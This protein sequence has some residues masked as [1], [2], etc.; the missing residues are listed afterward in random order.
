MKK[1]IPEKYDISDN[2]I[3]DRKISG[4][5]S[6]ISASLDSNVELV[7]G[8]PGFPITDIMNCFLHRSNIDSKWITNEKSALETA[9]GASVSGRRSI[10]LTKHVGMNVLCDPLI[11]SATHTIGSGLVIIA[12]DDPGV[13]A[14]QNEQDSRWYGPIAETGVFDPSTPQDVYDAIIKGFEISENA[15]IPVII[16]IT[17]RLEK[18]QK[19]VSRSGNKIHDSSIQKKRF[20]RSMW[21]LTMRGKHQRLHAKTYPLLV[22]ESENSYL[23]RCN[24]RGK[25]IGIIS[26]G[27]PSLITEDVI[28][29]SKF[30]SAISHLILNMVHPVP[31]EMLSS[32]SKNHR[33]ILIIEET[34]PFIES[35]LHILDNVLGKMSGHVPY[36][37]ID[38][39]HI[40]FAID[41]ISE[42]RIDKYNESV[43]TIAKRGA[44]LLCDECPY[45]ALYHLL[46]KL[47]VKYNINVAGDLGCSIRSAP[48]PLEAVDTGFSLGSAISVACGFDKKGIAVIGDF[49][50]AHSGITGLINALYS[51][52]DV[53][54]IVLKNE[55]AAM[56]G[57]QCAPDLTKI[58]KSMVP[59]FSIINMSSTDKT[60]HQDSLSVIIEN[61]L[62]KKGVSVLVLT[63][64][65]KKFV[66]LD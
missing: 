19:I 40:E 44:R 50:L 20:D 1:S 37:R 48:S 31:F 2:N 27:Y 25:D 28:N 39:E 47:K 32:F 33:Y 54:V 59:D 51:N 45:L 14:S 53:C 35:R 26:S 58:L 16:R 13:L 6:I 49:G 7:V 3:S 66:Q 11:T 65:C 24:M 57:G 38:R 61:K 5:E 23:N 15:S 55:V 22:F 18:S 29:S 64:K 4:I 8:V 10:V 52:S 46:K 56:T 60:I 36:G 42:A 43:E 63:G 12:G 30:N 9:L 21:D 62:R 41:H 34:E 17:N